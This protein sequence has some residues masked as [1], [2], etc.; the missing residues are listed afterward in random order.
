MEGRMDVAGLQA[1]LRE[2][3]RARDWEKFHDPKNLAMALT[4]EAAELME[5]FQWSTARESLEARSD[6]ATLDS[7]REELADVLIY[8]LRLADV[9]A[10]DLDAAVRMKI[11][12]NAEKYPT[13]L[14]KG[15][16]TKYNRR[17]R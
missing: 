3:A 17:A 1:E 9:L 12:A 16:A 7:I 13:G 5:L 11:D 6:D 2:F 14:S 8:L 10:I 4:V 15:N